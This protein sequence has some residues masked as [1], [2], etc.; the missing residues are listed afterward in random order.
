MNL[1]LR[2]LTPT[3]LLLAIAPTA[4]SQKLKLSTS[5]DSAIYYYYEGWRQVM[6]VADYTASEKAYRK[7]MRFDEKFLLGLSLLGRITRDLEER[8]DIE[9]QLDS[10]KHELIG[11]ER[12]LL[13]DYIE[14]V[15]LTNL[16]E[17]DPEA[18]EKQLEK[19]FQ[20]SEQNL[21]II[22]PAYPDEIYYKAEYI[23]VLHRNY[24][25]QRA[26]DSLYKI[27]SIV[28]QNEPFLLGYAAHMEAE[29]K[30][31]DNALAKAS[32]LVKRT[33]NESSPKPHVVYG[34]VYFEMGNLAESQVHIDK[35]LALDSGN[36]DALRLKKKID[37]ALKR[38]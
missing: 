23:E 9:K 12:L 26:L 36:I 3:L 18:A 22:V 24:G 8:L 31:F 33:T 19:A 1:V 14:L 7:M 21:G 4:Q 25:P 28:Q 17:T 38:K 10:R 5:S 30:N 27:A 29:A 2:I 34:D 13:D 16:R 11:H 15:K 37:E 20:T 6:D 32:E 35:A